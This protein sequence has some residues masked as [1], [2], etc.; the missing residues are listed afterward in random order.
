MVQL[1]LLATYTSSFSFETY[2]QPRRNN[3]RVE[4][5]FL[6]ESW[7]PNTAGSGAKRMTALKKTWSEPM[8]MHDFLL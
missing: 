1:V 7:A 2:K 8:I 5:F 4:A 6:L 3:T